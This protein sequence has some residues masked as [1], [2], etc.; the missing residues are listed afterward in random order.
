MAEIRE[1]KKKKELML[2]N[3]MVHG[4]MESMSSDDLLIGV[5]HNQVPAV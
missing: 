4:L 2:K 1:A 5:A 3:S